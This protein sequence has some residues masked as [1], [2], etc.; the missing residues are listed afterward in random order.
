MPQFWC[1]IK[2]VT[3]TNIHHFLWPI[4]FNHKIDNIFHPS[5]IRDQTRTGVSSM[6]WCKSIIFA[7]HSRLPVIK[8]T[9][10]LSSGLLP[11]R[12]L[13]WSGIASRG[14][15]NSFHLIVTPGWRRI[16]RHILAYMRTPEDTSYA[17][18][19]QVGE[20]LA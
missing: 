2:T 4:R 3:T 16:N 9:N 11:A 13:C 18:F 8:L 5:T 7:N 12:C 17:L 19:W 10:G 6:A 15:F 1:K 14:L 20:M